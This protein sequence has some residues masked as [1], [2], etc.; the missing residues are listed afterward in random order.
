MLN[1]NY[2]SAKFIM[3]HHPERTLGNTHTYRYDYLIIFLFG[4]EEVKGIF[5][6]FYLSYIELFTSRINKIKHYDVI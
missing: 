5:L 2:F 3:L 6:M 4:A 1:F